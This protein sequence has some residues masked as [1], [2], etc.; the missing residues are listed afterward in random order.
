MEPAP[1]PAPVPGVV[2][3]VSDRC[4]R[5]EAE[6]VSG[7]LATRLLAGIG[8]EA[9]VVVV[10]DG[11]TSVRRAIRAALAAGARVVLTTGGTGVG[12]RDLT[13]EGTGPLLVRELPGLAEAIR[14]RGAVAVPTAVLSRGLAGIA[15]GA[16]GEALV[17]NVPGSPGGR[18]GR[19]RRPG[20]APPARPRPARRRRALSRVSRHAGRPPRRRRSA[21]PRP[22]RSAHVSTSAASRPRAGTAVR[23]SG[24]VRARTEV[25]R[26]P[27][28][29]ASSRA[30][31]AAV[32]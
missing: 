29:R 10:P 24:A 13:P 27:G 14:A 16:T 22:S 17:V 21:P 7:P 18:A 28:P 20:P 12:P 11:V 15:A 3:T 1:S 5:G 26:S 31:S 32:R 2:I 4:A 19:G 30:R 8:V 6:D 25:P 23:C 9:P